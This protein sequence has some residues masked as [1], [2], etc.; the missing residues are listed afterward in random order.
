M[1]QDPVNLNWTAPSFFIYYLNMIHF[2]ITRCPEC[3]F[4]L[5][6][7]LFHISTRIGPEAAICF[8][9]K[10]EFQTG[11]G[12]WPFETKKELALFVVFSAVCI[13]LGGL[14]GGNLLFSAVEIWKGNEHPANVPFENPFFMSLVYGCAAALL[15]LQLVRTWLSAQRRAAGLGPTRTSL[16]SPKLI[17]GTQVKMI[18]FFLL[19][20]FAALLKLKMSV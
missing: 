4:P 20:Y 16:L 10:T 8:K 6:F 11:R 2:T 13:A 12:E 5:D 14:I 1:E 15:V 18:I 17:F 9:C 3:R 7:S 19:I